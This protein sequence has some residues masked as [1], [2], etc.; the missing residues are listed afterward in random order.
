M[1]EI[2][3]SFLFLL[4]LPLNP[5]QLSLFL[6]SLILNPPRSVGYPLFLSIWPFIFLISSP[7]GR[8]STTYL[9]IS[10]PFLYNRVRLS[11]ISPHKVLQIWSLISFI[12]LD[13]LLIYPLRLLWVFLHRSP[14]SSLRYIFH[15]FFFYHFLYQLGTIPLLL[16]S[17]SSTMVMGYV[18]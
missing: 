17:P 13:L 14:S 3:Y 8:R 10:L 18:D 4:F 11:P 15:R 1:F 9:S 2:P 16:Q 7:F 12:N 6:L 5:S